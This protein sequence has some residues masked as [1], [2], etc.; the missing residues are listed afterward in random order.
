MFGMD[1]RR[2]GGGG[3]LDNL[4]GGGRFGESESSITIRKALIY[5]LN[6]T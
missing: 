1:Q 6:L 5:S 3:Y 4:V 2:E